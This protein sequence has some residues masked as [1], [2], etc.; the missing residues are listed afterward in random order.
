MNPTHCL[1]QTQLPF[2]FVLVKFFIFLPLFLSFLLS[3]VVRYGIPGQRPHL[4]CFL[5][6]RCQFNFLLLGTLTATHSFLSPQS[7]VEPQCGLEVSVGW[8][9]K[10]CSILSK[11]FVPEMLFRWEDSHSPIKVKAR[12]Y[13]LQPGFPKCAFTTHHPTEPFDMTSISV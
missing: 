1:L 8:S 12:H 6:S 5:P 7:V 9:P 13:S 3:A 4:Y 11:C 10:T 2:F